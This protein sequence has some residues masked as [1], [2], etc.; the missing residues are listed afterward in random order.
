MS[1]VELRQIIY[2]ESVGTVGREMELYFAEISEGGAKGI[3][4]TNK[5]RLRLYGINEFMWCF[6]T[7]AKLVFFRFWEVVNNYMKNKKEVIMG[8][9]FK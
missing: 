8:L 2:Y 7:N 3:K 5:N 4:S 9:K 1:I 6:I